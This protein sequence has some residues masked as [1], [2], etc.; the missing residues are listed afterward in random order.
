MRHGQPGRCRFDN[1]VDASETYASS[2]KDE[3][4]IGIP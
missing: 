2:A 4:E 1:N 3:L